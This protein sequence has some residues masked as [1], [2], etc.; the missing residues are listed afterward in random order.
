MRLAGLG[1]VSAL[2]LTAAANAADLSVP[3]SSGGL[4]DA[5]LYA[6]NIWTGFYAG[7]HGGAA[8]GTTAVADP[9]G[10]SIFGD[11]INNTGSFGGGQIG[12]NAQF[13]RIVAGIEADVSF[14]DIEGTNT[15]FAASGF[16][17]SANCRSHIDWFGTLTARL[18][19][20]VGPTDQALLYVKGGAAW[21][22]IKVDSFANGGLIAA[23][24]PGES[25]STS[26]TKWG[27]TIGAGVEYKLNPRWSVKAEYNYLN[28]GSSPFTTPTQFTQIAP[29]VPNYLVT[30][31]VPTHFSDDLHVF[32]VG[33]N[34]ALNS[35]PDWSGRGSFKDGGSAF[36]SGWDFD[37]GARYAANFNS[38]QK[39]LGIA[40]QGKNS[41]ASRLTYGNTVSNGGELFARIDTPQNI[42]VKGF[43]GFGGG[44]NGHMHDEDW[45]AFGGTVPYSNTVSDIHNNIVYGTID[46][47]YDIFRDAGY[48]VAPFVGYTALSENMKA[49][50]CT[51]IANPFSDCVPAI[52]TSV[53]GIT[54]KDTWQAVRLGSSIEAVILP[55]L[56]LTAEAAWLPYVSFSGTDNHVLRALVSPETGNGMG[57]QFEASLSYAVT[58][59]WN[60]GIGGRYSTE[61]TTSGNTNFGGSGVHI[62][63][64]FAADQA[65]GFVQL[66]YRFGTVDEPL[67]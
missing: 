65:T 47:G 45:L 33:T 67:K 64:R 19:T 39:D 15:C 51:Q 48:K 18:G 28:F 25:T 43:V 66:S 53:L 31:G 63:Q 23:P 1:F 11:K 40:G 8:V 49:F 17:V 56:K 20:T 32:K 16:I 5:P 38:F 46:V 36:V 61:W 59:N 4:K 27:W 6:P 24:F 42:M 9:F 12:Y 54:E 55:R 3:Q 52:P 29:P 62:P 10:P 7:T 2:A 50:G 41:L 35:A 37:I 30:P 60:A 34:Y 57:A 58:P 26:D 22:N 13:D 21:E 14:A 44:D